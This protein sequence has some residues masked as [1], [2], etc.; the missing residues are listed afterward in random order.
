GRADHSRGGEHD[1]VVG[2]HAPLRR[3]GRAD[4]AQTLRRGLP[5][6]RS[7]GAPAPANPPRAAR[8]TRREHHRSRL[9]AAAPSRRGAQRRPPGLVRHRAGPPRRRPG[10]RLAA[11]GAGQAPEASGRGRAARHRTHGDHHTM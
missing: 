3:G 6:L 5:P 4:R 8:R 10:R 7:R 2:S 1:R 11:V 9:R